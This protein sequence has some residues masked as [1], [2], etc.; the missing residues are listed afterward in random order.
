MRLL[1]V[2]FSACALLA[3]AGCDLLKQGAG[4][5]AVNQQ[6]T[7]AKPAETQAVPPPEDQEISVNLIYAGLSPGAEK[8]ALDFD[9]KVLWGE[10]KNTSKQ[11]S[12]PA[13]A[14]VGKADLDLGVAKLHVVPKIVSATKGK[15]EVEVKDPSGGLIGRFDIAESGKMVELKQKPS[16]YDARMIYFDN[17]KRLTGYT[18][19]KAGTRKQEMGLIFVGKGWEW[20][21]SHKKPDLSKG[22]IFPEVDLVVLP[23]AWMESNDM[24]RSCD[25]LKAGTV[26]G[27]GMCYS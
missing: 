19:Y 27:G 9:F 14:K 21:E 3:L 20:V 6:L 24:D 25:T 7:T 16:K 4:A 11:V 17:E 13:S 22:Y 5:P 15:Y 23:K 26:T 1:L 18:I 12:V 8:K 2:T 10:Y